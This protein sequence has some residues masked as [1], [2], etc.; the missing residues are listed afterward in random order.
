MDLLSLGAIFEKESIV[1]H[2]FC[3]KVQQQQKSLG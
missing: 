3:L 1:E 2:L